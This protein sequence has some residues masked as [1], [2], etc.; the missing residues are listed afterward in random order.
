M[1]MSM[2]KEHQS[3]QAVKKEI[4]GISIT[5]LNNNIVLFPNRLVEMSFCRN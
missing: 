5:Q 4:Q 3:K 2:V 1:L